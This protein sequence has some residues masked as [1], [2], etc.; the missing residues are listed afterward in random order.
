MRY[1]LLPSLWFFYKNSRDTRECTRRCVCHTYCKSIVDIFYYQEKMMK[2][3]QCFQKKIK[4]KFKSEI[5][6][7]R[8]SLSIDKV[9]WKP[10]IFNQIFPIFPNSKHP[11]YL[12]KKHSWKLK[13]AP[14]ASRRKDVTRKHLYQ[15]TLF[16][17][18]KE[19][20][21]RMWLGLERLSRQW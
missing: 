4:F 8:I 10:L 11:A 9:P 5:S 3:K 19:F 18:G 16:S 17:N 6:K 15:I 7:K 13:T 2:K 1:S 20:V 12:K 21:Y 14:T